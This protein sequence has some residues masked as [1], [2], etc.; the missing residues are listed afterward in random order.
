ML[1]TIIQ[2]LLCLLTLGLQ[3]KVQHD[4]LFIGDE[5]RTLDVNVIAPAGSEVE[6]SFNLVKDLS[7]MAG[8]D[9]I[10]TSTR[11]VVMGS[12][13]S[14][15]VSFSFD[16]IAPGFYEVDLSAGDYIHPSFNIGIDPELIDSPADREEDFTAFWEKALTELNSVPMKLKLTADS[17]ASNELRT[18]YIVEAMSIDGV[19]MG[20]LLC[21]PVADGK[22]PVF[23][24]YMGYGADVYKYDPSARPD[25][26][27]FLVSVRDQG[28]FRGDQSR[29]IDR[30]L[31]S[32]ESFYY[33]GAFCD[34]VRA[35]DIV[36]CI[37]K[38][39][40]SRIFARGESQ[41]GALTIAAAALDHRIKAAAPA[42]PF[43][44]DYRDYSKIVWWPVWEVF[45]TADEMGL[46]RDDLFST[47]SY[48]DIK[49]L[50][51]LVD[52]PVFMAFGLQD[53]TCPP[54]TN[55]SAYNLITSQKQYYCAP[56]CGHAMWQVK[57]WSEKREK[58]FEQ[59]L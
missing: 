54:H 57:E 3:V 46:D 26:I 10:L 33:R 32:K 31:E 39:D 53:P 29:W 25:A 21:V 1:T 19:K 50:A 4:W 45:E 34:A 47:L 52:C 28:I 23:I 6:V 36:C 58:W 48:F 24:D 14:T 51:G 20:G 41:G 2:T 18:S 11:K 49:N 42:V 56:E 7:L 13:D 55:F 40:T 16:G 30:G 5:V 59:Y 27:E 22:Y 9:T 43:L 15:T 38:A 35:I 37:D 12:Q 8:K 44:G 17:E